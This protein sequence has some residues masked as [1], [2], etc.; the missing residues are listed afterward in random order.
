MYPEYKAPR[1][2]ILMGESTA[3]KFIPRFT[4]ALD[5]YIKQG[6]QISLQANIIGNPF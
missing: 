6:G 3:G 4:K 1:K 2:I 5:G